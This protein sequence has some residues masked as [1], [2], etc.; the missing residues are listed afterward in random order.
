MGKGCGSR[1]Y[2]AMEKI[3]KLQFPLPYAQIVKI[4]V[5][6]YIFAFPL[7]IAASGSGVVTIPVTF[8]GTMIL[9]RIRIYRVRKNEWTP[10]CMR[11]R[12]L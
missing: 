8:A 6:I 11:H 9:N 1:H 2:W 10:F 7:V 12:H 3:D 5:I 4:L